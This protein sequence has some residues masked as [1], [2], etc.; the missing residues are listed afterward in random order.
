MG[1][2]L[3]QVRTSEYIASGDASVALQTTSLGSCVAVALYDATARVGGMAHCLLDR[4][5]RFV[6]AGE[7]QAQP[8]RCADSAIPAL[9]DAM[10]ALGAL[11]ERLSAWVAGGGN[12]FTTP[13]PVYDVGNWN[14]D[15]ARDTL[16]LLGIPIMAEDV[17]GV[18]ARR[19]RINVASGSVSV[20]RPAGRAEVL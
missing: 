17:G 5:A 16:L 8:G 15:A 9:I 1:D 10:V 18:T 13:D 6:D 11:P 20:I 2:Q 3:V 7:R 12:M 19:L 4:K 14:V